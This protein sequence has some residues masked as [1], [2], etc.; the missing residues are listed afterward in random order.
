MIE[1]EMI[2]PEDFIFTRHESF[3]SCIFVAVLFN[4]GLSGI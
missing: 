3:R 4:V 1:T 2:A